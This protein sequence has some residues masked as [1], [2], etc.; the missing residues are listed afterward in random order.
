MDD[1]VHSLREGSMYSWEWE[2][3]K[4]IVC[5]KLSEGLIPF[6][7]ALH[8]VD[9]SVVTAGG[10]SWTEAAVALFS[11]AD[12]GRF[13]PYSIGTVCVNEL[14]HNLDDGIQNFLSM[15]DTESIRFHH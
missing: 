15:L 6:R 3:I 14:G 8:R 12:L 13:T 5:R 10:W 9:G 11:T 2:I 4:T 7:L 1:G